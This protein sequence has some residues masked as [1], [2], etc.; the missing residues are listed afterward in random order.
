MILVRAPQMPIGC[1]LFSYLMTFTLRSKLTSF[2][3]FPGKVLKVNMW[4]MLLCEAVAAV[5][6]K[7]FDILGIKPVQRM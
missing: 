2:F 6:A 1:Y 7:G 3:F 5:M 4:R